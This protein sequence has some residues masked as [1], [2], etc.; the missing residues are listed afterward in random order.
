MSLQ[1][2]LTNALDLNVTQQAILNDIFPETVVPCD[3]CTCHIEV[4]DVVVLNSDFEFD[5]LM[6]VVGVND[7]DDTAFVTWFSGTDMY[8]AELPLVALSLI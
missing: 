8:D 7:E 1:S 3:E 2:E 6:T 5:N 4:G